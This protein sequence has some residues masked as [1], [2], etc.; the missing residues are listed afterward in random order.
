MK[1]E[2]HVTPF[3]FNVPDGLSDEEINEWLECQLMDQPES[4]LCSELLVTIGW[5][6]LRRKNRKR[7]ESKSN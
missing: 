6:A 1:I 5:S 7:P 4:P 2:I 3:V